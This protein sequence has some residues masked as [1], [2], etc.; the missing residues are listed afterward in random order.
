MMHVTF[1][2]ENGDSTFR[3]ETD[4]DTYECYETKEDS[5]NY[6]ETTEPHGMVE[7]KDILGRKFKN[8]GLKTISIL[9]V[10][11]APP[12]EKVD[13]PFFTKMQCLLKAGKVIAACDASVKNG[14]IGVW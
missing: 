1:K 14:V 6:F 13:K 10:K 12:T 2:T 3:H 8:V 11:V 5:E 7:F 9:G 4:E